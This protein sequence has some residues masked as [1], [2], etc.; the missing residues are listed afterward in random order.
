MQL[1]QRY[2]VLFGIVSNYFIV[3]KAFL[4]L[5]NFSRAIRIAYVYFIVYGLFS[6]LWIE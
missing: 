1:R 5:V 4:L 3:Y 2:G 6:C